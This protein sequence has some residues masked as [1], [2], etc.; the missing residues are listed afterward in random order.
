MTVKIRV[1]KSRTINLGNYNSTK[2]EYGIEDELS[3]GATVGDLN[4]HQEKLDDMVN[5]WLET[6]HARWQE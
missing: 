4:R 1:T 6:E 5:D 3:E 2:I